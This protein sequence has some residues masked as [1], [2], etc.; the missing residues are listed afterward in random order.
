MKGIVLQQPPTVDRDDDKDKK[1]KRKPRRSKQNPSVSEVA[2]GSVDETLVEASDILE[3]VEQ[4]PK[5]SNV[6]FNSVPT[7]IQLTQNN[8]NMQDKP[9]LQYDL[10]GNVVSKA[11]PET[12]IPDE[13]SSYGSSNKDSHI[14]HQGSRHRSYFYPHWSKEAVDEAIVKGNVYTALFRVNMHNRLEAYCKIDGVPVDVLINGIISQNRAVEGDTVAI[15]IDPVSLWPKIKGPAGVSTP[16]APSEDCNSVS[17]ICEFA[18]DNCKGKNKIEV[19]NEYVN[20]VPPKNPSYDANNGS[21]LQSLP[22]SDCG[23]NS[24]SGYNTLASN[25]SNHHNQN[26][27]ICG[28]EKLFSMISSSPNK[29]PTGRVVA[30]TEMSSRRDAVVGFLNV[31]QLVSTKE[32]YKREGR[33]KKFTREFIMFTPT[34]LKFPKMTIRVRDLPE[35][36]KRRLDE[37]DLTV[38]MELVGVC[39]TDWGED[40]YLPQAYITHIFG[41]GGDIEAQIAAISFENSI[42]SSEFSPESLLCIPQVPWKI[43]DD[44]IRRRADLREM[45]IFTIDPSSAT[46]LDD[47]LSVLTLPDGNFRV[48]VHIADVSY[49]VLP[50][51]ALDIE[52]QVR[53]TSV[54]LLHG[55]LPMLPPLLSDGLGSLNPGVDRLCFSI[56]WDIN[57]SGEIMNRWIGRSVI[58]S[59]CKLSYENVQNMIDGNL[60]DGWF[61][62][63]HGQFQKSDIVESVKI[64]QKISM[65]FRDKRFNDGALH[66]DSSK[67]TFLFD[68]NGAPYDSVFYERTESHIL[69]EEFMLLANRTVAEIISKAYPNCALLRRHPDPDV[70]KLREFEGYCA[71]HGLALDASS[72]RSLHCSLE[73]IR[74][75]LKNDSVLFNILL[76]HAS[77]PMQPAKYFCTGDLKENE[78]G[79]YAL[80]FPFYTHFTSPLRRYPDI[81]VHRTLLATLEAEKIY[82]SNGNCFTGIYFDKIAAES[83]KG[84]E[85][86]SVA[87]LKYGLPC[88]EVLADVA[89]YC[90]DRKYA[91]RI[92][93]DSTEKVYMWALLKKNEILLTKA[94]VLAL[95]P[96]FMSIYIPKLAIERRIYYDEVD[97]IVPEWLDMT[98]TLVISLNTNK[99]VNRRASSGKYKTLDDVVL[100]ECPFELKLE[101]LGNELG[102]LVVDDVEPAVF[103][104]TVS[105]LSTITIAVHAVGGDDGPLDMKARLYVSSYLK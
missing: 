93:K 81:L 33:K 7:P 83:A 105:L 90:N 103:P 44:E 95:G 91:S 80:G 9:V 21:C 37:G 96:K 19:N 53:T 66:L 6:D 47:A 45:C 63:L 40:D 89:A 87:A 82:K 38:D 48:S 54:Y 60:D 17:E 16:I 35:C 88:P 56:F 18:T 50:D 31:K 34:D 4:N 11:C 5:Q 1:K 22:M 52:A 13:P 74:E 78:W 73:Q 12:T 104:L 49:F 100:I 26:G 25:T 55:K 58:K 36:I 75:K 67:L 57:L 51:T 79:H 69:V 39:V 42:R 27:A 94:R 59:C 41:K 3:V 98:S 97:D 85:A 43:P 20:I 99:R 32:N 72:S 77:K 23:S 15:K 10:A 30:I 28:K 2:C 29:R 76:S 92:A 101:E 64:L 102:D 61:P 24:V 65:I 46:D 14:P 70:R 68:D 84:R 8:G 71:K 62:E 86:L